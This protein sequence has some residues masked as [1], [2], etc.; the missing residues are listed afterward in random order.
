MLLFNGYYFTT[1]YIVRREICYIVRR[2]MLATHLLT[3]TF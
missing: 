2:E 1:C 3:H